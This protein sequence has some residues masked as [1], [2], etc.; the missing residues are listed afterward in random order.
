MFLP[1][2]IPPLIAHEAPLA[3]SPSH[4]ST[5]SN[6][7][8]STRQPFRILLRR[9]SPLPPFPCTVIRPLNNRIFQFPLRAPQI[10]SPL[11]SCYIPTL[12]SFL[13]LPNSSFFLLLSVFSVFVKFQS[14]WRPAF[15][16][17]VFK[18][19]ARPCFGPP[20]PWTMGPV[21][22]FCRPICFTTSLDAGTGRIPPPCSWLAAL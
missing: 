4:F 15:F 2:Q 14:A 19:P 12:P 5:S 18:D 6:P 20:D 13:F 7:P 17:L 8:N 22:S 16:A 21:F 9:T 11:L 1:H 3:G 10:Q